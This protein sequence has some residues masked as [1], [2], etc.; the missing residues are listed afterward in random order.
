MSRGAVRAAALALVLLATG[1]RAQDSAGPWY[2]GRQVTITV[3]TPPGSPASLYAQLLSRHMGRHLPGQPRILVHHLPGAGGLT[4]A[5]TAYLTMPRDGTALVSTNSAIFLEP[6][7]GGRGAQ[8]DARRYTWIGG[9][10]VERM[11]CV[12]WHTSNVRT[13]ADA[14]ARSAIIGSYGAEGPSAVFAR[15]ANK[16]AGTRFALITGYS[17]NQEALVAMQR[18]EIDGS[19]AMGWHE[20]SLRRQDWLRDR[21]VNVLLQ[22]GLRK[23]PGLADVPLLLDHARS[24]EDQGALRLLYTPLEFGRPVY[25]PPGVPD[26]RVRELRAALARALADPELQAETQRAGLPVQHVPGERIGELIEEIY[27]AP[28]AVIDRA[29]SD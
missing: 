8:F 22:M 5:N 17:G 3:G 13:L 28:Q 18:G 19:C 4:A 11:T 12:T 26:D 24:A 25:A 29:R 7:L 9:T 21:L 16:L 10:H 27:G 6:L 23:E 2:A 1:A 20:L 14:M 15:A